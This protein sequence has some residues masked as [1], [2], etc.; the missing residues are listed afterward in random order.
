MLLNAQ[1]AELG[2]LGAYEA[3]AL[4]PSCEKTVGVSLG[5]SL[6]ENENKYEDTPTGDFVRLFVF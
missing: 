2:G 5:A 1:R 3:V 4:Q 6:H